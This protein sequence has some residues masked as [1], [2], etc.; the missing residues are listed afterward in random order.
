MI[1]HRVNRTELS[2]LSF[3]KRSASVF[4]DKTAVVH[5][6]RSYSYRH[7]EERVNRQASALRNAGLKK[8]DRVA[9]LSPNAPAMLEAHFGVP[10]AGGVLVAINIR[11][12]AE[13]VGYIVEHSGARF[14][15]AYAE[16]QPLVE[17]LDLEGIRVIRIDFRMY[18][19]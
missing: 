14:L 6:T 3:L 5:G 19:K 17:A 1:H 16:L 13:E 18:K 8:G 7:F 10:A 2:P 9:F 12:N 4:A 11:L 15:F